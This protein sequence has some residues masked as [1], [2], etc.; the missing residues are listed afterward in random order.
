MRALIPTYL[1]LRSKLDNEK[2]AT[3]V[4]YALLAALIAAALVGGITALSGGIGTTFST[5]TAAL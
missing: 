1:K 4:E 3:M 2:G 5:V